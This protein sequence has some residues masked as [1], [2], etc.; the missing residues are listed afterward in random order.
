MFTP[1]VPDANGH[2]ARFMTCEAAKVELDGRTIFRA[3]PV[4]AG[5]PADR[6]FLTSDDQG[7]MKLFRARAGHCRPPTQKLSKADE[8]SPIARRGHAG[9]KAGEL[10]VTKDIFSRCDSADYLKSEADIAAHFEAITTEEDDDPA[11][12]ALA[13]D[14]ASR[15]RKLLDSASNFRG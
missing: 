12:M 3:R 4:H 9:R 2:S 7:L 10:D 11:V 5:N 13:H 8:P 15:A 6:A 1:S 14:V